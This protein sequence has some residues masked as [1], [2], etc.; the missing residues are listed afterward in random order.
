MAS[1]G[2]FVDPN[3]D[4]SDKVKKVYNVTPGRSLSFCGLLTNSAS[5]SIVSTLILNPLGSH[6]YVSKIAITAPT[7][8][9]QCKFQ[10]FNNTS[11]LYISGPKY[12]QGLR[13]NELILE[14]CPNFS[15][16]SVV[17]KLID[18]NNTYVIVQAT[19]KY[20]SDGPKFS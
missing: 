16:G 12:L 19:Y 11:E 14:D 20:D 2:A 8:G 1:V 17:V 5:G 3:L 18:A 10:I 6:N 4:F 9:S 7:A 13:N 15:T